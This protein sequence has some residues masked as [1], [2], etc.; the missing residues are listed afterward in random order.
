MVRWRAPDQ[1][2]GRARRKTSGVVK[3][4][5]IIDEADI[6]EFCIPDARVVQ[7]D[8]RVTIAK[9]IDNAR[10]QYPCVADSHSVVARL[11]L[12]Y[13][14]PAKIRRFLVDRV[15]LHGATPEQRSDC[16]R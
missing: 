7:L 11:I 1:A 12:A 10:A 6:G 5:E 9:A 2:R 8:S 13:W 14:I 3:P 16:P 15:V 4:I